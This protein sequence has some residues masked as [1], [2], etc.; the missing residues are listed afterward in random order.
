MAA[1]PKR[2]SFDLRDVGFQIVAP[3]PGRQ[4]FGHSTNPK[5]AGRMMH[6]RLDLDAFFQIG[7]VDLVGDRISRNGFAIGVDRH[8]AM[9]MV[10]RQPD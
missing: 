2:N 6:A 1:E 10:P 4:A 9:A 8:L 5:R 3:A 7:E